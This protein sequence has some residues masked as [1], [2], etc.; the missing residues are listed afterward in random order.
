ML[1]EMENLSRQGFFKHLEGDHSLIVLSL[2]AQ[3]SNENPQV[4]QLITAEIPSAD[5]S[6]EEPYSVTDV[7]GSILELYYD[8]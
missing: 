5:A 3:E 4:E 6:L 1:N 7:L 8:S 2:T